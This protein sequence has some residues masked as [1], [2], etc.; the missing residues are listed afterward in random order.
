MGL[1]G[2][3]RSQPSNVRRLQPLRVL[4]VGRDE[5]FM[6]VTSFLLS[7]RGYTVKRSTLADAVSVAE[8]E[9]ADVVLVELAGSRVDAGR[10]VAALQAC[11]SEPALVLLAKN[12]DD[13]W[14]GLPTLPKWTPIDTLAA[15]VE[16]AGL[17]RRQPL[18]HAAS[19][20]ET[21]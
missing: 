5:R 17:R 11:A 1:A 6:R 18:P 16:S 7:R 3:H 21:R 9:R 14:Q 2:D 19:E 12:G 8:R 10:T 13:A 20:G 15:A 4:V